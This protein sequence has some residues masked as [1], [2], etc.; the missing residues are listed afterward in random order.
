MESWLDFENNSMCY[1]CVCS[2]NGVDAGCMERDP[3]FCEY[4]RNL[5]RENAARDRYRIAFGYDAPT[6]ERQLPWRLRRTM[7]NGMFDLVE[8]GMELFK[9]SFSVLSSYLHFFLIFK[10]MGITDYSSL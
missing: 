4:Y 8:S 2:V 7:D 3:W 1:Y 10:L 5:K 9:G 6:Y